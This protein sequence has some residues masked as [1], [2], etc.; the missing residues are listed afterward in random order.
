MLSSFWEHK[1]HHLIA[2]RVSSLQS[3]LIET[4][5]KVSENY[6]MTLVTEIDPTQENCCDAQ[7]N[8]HTPFIFLSPFKARE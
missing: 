5:F 3:R 1:Y 7:I 2:N 8:I 6:I 4:V